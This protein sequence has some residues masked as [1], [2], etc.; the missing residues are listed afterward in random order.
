MPM[1]VA[2][3]L[4]V[5]TGVA[6]GL[7]LPTGDAPPPAPAAPVASATVPQPRETPAETVLERH[8]GGHFVAFADVNGATVRFLVDTGATSVALT[9]DD[10]RRA[11][12]PFDPGQFQ[13]VGRGASGDVRGQV[14]TIRTMAIDGKRADEVSGVVLENSDLSLLGQSYLRRLASVQISGDTMTLR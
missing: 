3:L 11:G 7:S 5:V 13:V 8:G 1:R 14:V 4:T 2:L 12:I 6:I 10:A 9:Q